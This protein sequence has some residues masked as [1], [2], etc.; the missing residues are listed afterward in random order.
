MKKA[1]KYPMKRKDF[2][3]APGCAVEARLDPLI[4]RKVY[5]EVPPRGAYCLSEIGESLRPVADPLKAWGE[6]HQEALSCAPPQERG[7]RQA[8]QQG[9]PARPISGR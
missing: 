5:A 4:F 3:H 6:S 2:G 7:G 1:G 9:G 8:N